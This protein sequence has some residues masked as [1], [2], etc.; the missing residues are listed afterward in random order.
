MLAG[1]E[2]VS[3][4]YCKYNNTVCTHL[5]FL[6]VNLVSVLKYWAQLDS[7]YSL[8]VSWSFSVGY[9]SRYRCLCAGAARVH[10]I[11][12]HWVPSVVIK[13]V[14]SVLIAL[15]IYIVLHFIA[16]V[17]SPKPFTRRHEYPFCLLV[18]AQWS[19]AM[20]ECF[21]YMAFCASVQLQH[22]TCGAPNSATAGSPGLEI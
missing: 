22:A 15:Q 17:P 20:Q 4:S 11:Q 3:S 8:G 12:F 6:I 18:R 2:R 21:S 5:L 13:P 9:V 7:L 14:L 10:N 1:W 16:K 19:A